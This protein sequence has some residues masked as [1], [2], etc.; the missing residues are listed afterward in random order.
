MLKNAENM[1]IDESIWGPI[2]DKH[3]YIQIQQI[4]SANDAFSVSEY[5]EEFK[6]QTWHSYAQLM[7]C[8]L[9]LIKAD[10]KP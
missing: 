4:W 10:V 3:K 5:S 6:I 1:M 9:K 8:D 7:E 2:S